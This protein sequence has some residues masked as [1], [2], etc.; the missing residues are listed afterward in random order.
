[1]NN[2]KSNYKGLIGLSQVDTDYI[3]STT[4]V[5]TDDITTKSLHTT[6]LYV[7]NAILDFT[8]YVDL[9][10]AQIIAA[11]KSFSTAPLL[12]FTQT[13]AVNNNLVSRYYTDSRYVDL[14]SGQI[15][16]G[17]KYFNSA[18]YLNFTQT[19]PTANDVINKNYADA[20]YQ[21]KTTTAVNSGFVRSTVAAVTGITTS[22]YTTI[23]SFTIPTTGTYVI[24]YTGRVAAINAVG[25]YGGGI[26]ALYNPAGTIIGDSRIMILSTPGSSTNGQGSASGT[27]IVSGT[28]GTYTMRILQYNGNSNCLNDA[29]GYNTV[30]YYEV[31]AAGPAGANGTNGT[32]GITPVLSIGTVSTLSAGSNA[33][34]TQTG[35]SIAPVYNFGIPQGIQG[36]Q[37]TQGIQ[38]STG[39]TGSTGAKGDKGDAGDSTVATAAAT[40][41]G[42][43]AAAAAVSAA[44]SSTS[45]AASA[46]SAL[47]AETAS[48]A[49]NG[50]ITTLENKT[51]GMTGYPDVNGTI[52]TEFKG[53]LSVMDDIGYE[54]I[55]LDGN[56]KSIILGNDV[57]KLDATEQKITLGST[58]LLN[59]VQVV[60]PSVW[61]NNID[62]RTSVENL[63]IGTNNG[64]L[65]TINI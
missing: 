48:T 27:Y 49:N 17:I 54:K 46:A 2:F 45:S 51:V 59:G 44:A 28:S 34:V 40:A 3:E 24:I 12:N 33:T 61:A 65:T 10:T 15:I 58:Q 36:V 20:T 22:S 57:I 47:A 55:K 60:S 52:H 62:A 9:T 42:I 5:N 31:A 56:N 26:M 25:N 8:Q 13:T 38:G 35:T 19:A 64:V 6:S 30:T 14:T 37:G 50:R 18:P 29:N 41:A 4:I 23:V 7:N 16:S 32:N 63:N 11:Q 43:S 53:K 1:M 39:A 21:P